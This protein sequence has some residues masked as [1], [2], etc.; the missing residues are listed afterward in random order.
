M[1]HEGLWWRLFVDDVYWTSLDDDLSWDDEDLDKPCL[2]LMT[3]IWFLFYLG[4]VLFCNLILKCNR[5][6]KIIVN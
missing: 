6:L 2:T 1:C 4:A 5:F 3:K